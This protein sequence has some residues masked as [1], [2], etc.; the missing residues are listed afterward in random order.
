MRIPLIGLFSMVTLRGAAEPPVVP[1]VHNR[2]NPVGLDVCDSFCA[3]RWD[4]HLKVSLC[5]PSPKEGFGSF[6][7]NFSTEDFS[8]DVRDVFRTPCEC[9]GSESV[10]VGTESYGSFGTEAHGSF[11][12]ESYGSFGT[13]NY[14][15]FGTDAHG[16]FE[17][18]KNGTYSVAV[19]VEG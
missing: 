17:S 5:L 1:S 14:G 18:E 16:S 13:E 6:C 7:S 19:G 11:A 2:P 8:L 10:N 9:N 3:K 15:S 4:D 12:T